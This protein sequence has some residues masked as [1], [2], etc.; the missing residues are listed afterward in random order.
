MSTRGL[1]GLRW[2][3]KDKITYNHCDSYPDGLGRNIAA[4]CSRHTVD[5]LKIIYNRIKL[6]DTSIPP[7]NKQKEICK[8]NHWCDF[9]VSTGRDDDWY[10]LT[11][12]LQG[13]F[14]ELSKT[15]YSSDTV[16]MLDCGKSMYNP[17]CWVEYAYVINLDTEELEFYEGFQK[18]PQKDGR[19]IAKDVDPDSIFL[20]LAKTLPLKNMVGIAS[21]VSEMI[22]ALRYD[23]E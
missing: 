16:F 2:H 1:Y 20:R 12:E 22:E 14:A 9:S 11:R 6:I 5:E 3:D 17:S 8:S 19:Y 10:C 7:T 13:N 4:F 23:D 21:T 15:L 18:T